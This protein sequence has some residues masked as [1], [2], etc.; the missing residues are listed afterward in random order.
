MSDT[1]WVA[2]ITA[3][4]TTIPQIIIAIINYYKE[5]KQKQLEL[6]EQNRLNAIVEFLDTIG[7]TYIKEGL[8]LNEK[9]RFDKALNKLLL[10]FPNITNS[11]ITKIFDST[12][13]WDSAKRSD[14][15]KPLIKQLS[16]SISGK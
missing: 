9:H 8:S 5:I 7:S 15:L 10:Y 1:I 14:A 3:L 11:E 13:E 12:K 16:K 2:I 6:F 4:A